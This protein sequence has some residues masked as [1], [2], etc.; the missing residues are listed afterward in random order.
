[1]SEYSPEKGERVLVSLDNI[2]W[3]AQTKEFLCMDNEQYVCRTSTNSNLFRRWPYIKENKRALPKDILC[4]VWDSKE[5]LGKNAYSR[6]DGTFHSDGR[7]SKTVIGGG[8]SFYKHYK[9][10]RNDP[11][12]W[13]GGE[14]P[15]PDGVDYRVFFDGAWHKRIKD[16]S[17]A[18]FCWHWDPAFDNIIAYQILGEIDGD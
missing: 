17:A 9:V 14:C 1:M 18:P 12:P 6:G 16:D 8:L 7:D 2:D 11:Q 13:F 5:E 4:K 15:I 3:Q 10:I